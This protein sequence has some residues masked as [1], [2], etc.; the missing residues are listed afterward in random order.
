MPDLHW[1]LN[2]ASF[3]GIAILAVPVWSLNFRRKRLT[4]LR[5][6]D[7]KA[8]SDTDFRAQARKLLIDRHRQNVD[9]WRP[10]DQACLAA[11]YLLLLGAAFL[12]LFVAS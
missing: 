12:R 5:Q 4:A 10:I 3:L 7:R 1:W 2:L 6:A 8:A 9:D 11:G